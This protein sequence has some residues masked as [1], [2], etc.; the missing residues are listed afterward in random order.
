MPKVFAFIVTRGNT[1]WLNKSIF[2][3]LGQ[4]KKVDTLYICD[5]AKEENRLKESRLNLYLDNIK[6]KIGINGQIVKKI[7][8]TDTKNFSSTIAKAIYDNNIEVANNLLWILHDDSAAYPNALEELLKQYEKTNAGIIGC[9]Q[10]FWRTKKIL[11]IGFSSTPSGKRVD[12]IWPGEIDQGQ[13][14]ENLE[15]FA[16]SLAGA[17]I[18]ANLFT[19]IVTDRSLYSIYL[20]S[21]DFCNKVRLIGKKVIVAPSAR[22]NHIG[23]SYRE[24]RGK[25]KSLQIAKSQSFYRFANTRARNI[26]FLLIYYFLAAPFK[27]ARS[28]ILKQPAVALSELVLPIILTVYMPLIFSERLK[29]KVLLGNFKKGGEKIKNSRKRLAEFLT[30]YTASR[31]I[32][33]EHKAYHRG[34]LTSDEISPTPL[35]AKL[36]VRKTRKR[37]L[38]LSFLIILVCSI[39]II[40][41]NSSIIKILSGGFF[42]GFGLAPSS[43]SLYDLWHAAASKWVNFGLGYNLPPNP[44]LFLLIPFTFIFGAFQTVLNL[45]I[46]LS[47]LLSA[48]GAWAAA[49]VITRK[50]GRRFLMALLWAFSPALIISIQRGHFQTILA[51]IAIPILFYS[52]IRAYGLGEKDFKSPRL[53]SWPSFATSAIMLSAVVAALPILFVPILFILVFCVRYIGGK[54]RHLF[55]LFL[56]SVLIVWPFLWQIVR[57]V[58]LVNL[59]TLFSDSAALYSPANNYDSANSWKTIFGLPENNAFSTSVFSQYLSADKISQIYDV[60]IIVLVAIIAFFAFF[61]L[62]KKARSRYSYMAWVII[63]LSIA[64]CLLTCRVVVGSF[65]NTAIYG[66]SGVPSGLLLFA[67][68]LLCTAFYKNKF[69]AAFLSFV[70]I[71]FICLAGLNF[72]VSDSG[73]A[74]SVKLNNNMPAVGIE[75]LNEN[76]NRRI[77]EITTNY[78]GSYN[79]S[80]L[81]NANRE[82]VDIAGSVN[83]YRA[84]QGSQTNLKDFEKQ[85]ATIVTQP[86]NA[87]IDVLEKYNISGI[88]IPSSEA[89]SGYYENLVSQINTVSGLQ[90][91]IV[92]QEAVYWR[93][94]KENT[95]AQK[96]PEQI[97]AE[98]DFWNN[99]FLFVKSFIFIAYLLMMV[100]IN[101]IRKWI[102]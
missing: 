42:S 71:C 67:L 9:K 49:G 46:I 8:I 44:M 74:N 63:I 10:L 57:Q 99:L 5:I 98:N 60:T 58:N 23:A 97:N 47:F 21:Q 62:L 70:A 91:V 83:T 59:R 100:P 16:V 19:A 76:P 79:Y 81:R 80:V 35:E 3:V 25:M 37:R 30:S 36:L 73:L 65:E 1:P 87:K 53:F 75:E 82:F 7:N 11:E 32:L 96:F 26:L 90:R 69:S 95:P 29:I 13:H 39:S 34:A 50:N 102:S 101:I 17:L 43:A 51:W 31:I 56:P 93:V 45:F 28:F 92:G 68:I 77:L 52:I 88:L 6:S 66:W 41:F 22:L 54:R 27:S 78:D 64:A 15:V 94:D 72:S 40:L 86:T 84:F 20:E 38:A 89:K 18:D 12:L 48:L 4:S 55:A 61:A 14:D 85:V 2:S 24:Q 33:K